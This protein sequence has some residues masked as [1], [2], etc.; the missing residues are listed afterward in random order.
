MT[1]M[2]KQILVYLIF[3]FLL[4][5]VNV[6]HANHTDISLVEENT[7]SITLTFDYPAFTTVYDQ[8]TEYQ[9]LTIDNLSVIR[10]QQNISVPVKP[11]R[12]LLPFATTVDYIEVETSNVQTIE[13]TNIIQ[14]Q[15]I[16]LNTFDDKSKESPIEQ[17]DNSDDSRSAIYD[18]RGIQYFRGY[19]VLHLNIYPIIYEPNA[20]IANFHQ[21]ITLKIITKN[22]NVN[23]LL[24]N[25]QQDKNELLSLIDNPDFIESYPDQP[26]TNEAT[27]QYD[28]VIITTQELLDADGLYTF[29]DLLSYRES[30]GL[31]SAYKTVESIVN[32]YD[33][34]DEK[35]KI[36]NFII[37]AYTNWGTTWVLLG[38]DIEQVPIRYL[39]DFDG[40]D[41]VVSSDLYYQCLDGN[42]NFNNDGRWGE[43]YDGVDGERIDLFAE[44]YIG[45]APVD[46]ADDVSAFVEKTISY[47]ESEW[48]TDDYLKNHLSVGEYTWNGPG[49]WGAGYVERCIDFCTEYNQATHGVSSQTFNIIELYERDS[50]WT[51]QELIQAINDGVGIINHVG[52][53]S[54]SAAMKLYFSD[55]LTLENE[56]KYSLLYSQACHS[57]QVE[58]QDCFAEEWVTAEKKGGFA[59]IMNSGVGYGGTINYDGAD[60]R[61]AREFFDALFSNTEQ[62]SSIG[63]AN[64]DSKEDNF[65]RIDEIGMHMYHVY[66][67]TNLFG[68]PYVKIKGSEGTIADFR[69]SP[70]YPETDDDIQFHDESTG[71]IISWDWRFGDGHYSSQQ[72]PSHEYSMAGDYTVKLS[73]MDSKGYRISVSKEIEVKDFWPPIVKVSYNY[74]GLNEFTLAF[75]GNESFDPDGYIVNWTWDFDDTTKVYTANTV[76]EFPDY[77]EYNAKLIVEDNEGNTANH[78]F[79]VEIIPI[80][81]P[82]NLLIT[83][84]TGG[85]SETLYNFQVSSTDP[86]DLPIQYYWDWGDDTSIEWTGYYGSGMTCSQ[87]HQWME[88]GTYE[89]R[90][91]AKNI[92]GLESDWSE[93]LT[94]TIV[95]NDPPIVELVNP[96]KGIFINNHK[97]F[98]F[99]RPIVFGDVTLEFSVVDGNGIEQVELYVN[100]L[101]IYTFLEEPYSYEWVKDSLIPLRNQIKIIAV[102]NSGKI[103]EQLFYIIKF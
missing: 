19:P 32:E 62:I 8:D 48:G 28:Y 65:W 45:R 17:N 52:H 16:V 49:G 93:A 64:Q 85:I 57:G 47:E 68:D 22:T 15:S 70:S 100:E 77:G 54:Y 73:I 75:S 40:Q 4:C 35:E 1:Q 37:D 99:I 84:S 61:Y 38:G 82:E 7:I 43:K 5:N 72:N 46:D 59:A 51:K 56:G 13:L 79:I 25:T 9:L 44:V 23:P 94:I 74:I 101:K 6:L 33:G 26:S 86:Q 90:V 18:N 71:N 83:G 102:D 39:W 36:R 60:N 11:I 103:T 97:V 69:W 63:K 2:N 55:I 58:K 50:S 21:Q 80:S 78:F 98:P 27:P 24:R 66:Y 95:Q 53:G 12:V 76:H 20:E 88:P 10:N 89:I 3:L 92:A 29:N 30:Q 34:L 87:I 42:Y 14:Q 67:N 31:S 91:K 81:P 96:S 41:L